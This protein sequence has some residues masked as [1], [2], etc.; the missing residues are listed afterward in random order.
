MSAITLFIMQSHNTLQ[1]FSLLALR[2]I[3]GAIFI[4]AGYAKWTYTMPEGT[5]QGMIYLIQFLSVVEPL[6]GG[7]LIV[8]FLTRWAAAGLALIMAGAVVML[9]MSM[10]V[11]FFTGQQ[12][13]GLD[14]NVLLLVGSLVLIAFEAGKWSIDAMRRK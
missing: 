1:N 14:Y 6:G 3:V 5:P 7:A 10:P 9:K 2:F 4:W 11:S 12:G 8:G 13:T